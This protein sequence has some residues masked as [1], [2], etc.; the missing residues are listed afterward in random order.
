VVDTGTNTVVDTI[1]VGVNALGIAIT[2]DGS[3]AYV[4]NNLSG[5]VSVIDIATNTVVA[6][7][8]MFQPVAV[9]VSPDGT[10]AYVTNSSETFGSVSVI[11]TA[12]NTVDATIVIGPNAQ[13]VAM[14]PDGSRAYA[15]S[16]GSDSVWV[17]DTATNSVITSVP[18][19]SAPVGVAVT[20]GIGP[21][22]A[23][24]QCKRGGWRTFTLPRTFK[25]QGECV[26]SVTAGK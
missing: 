11:D 9:A 13:G 16:F 20:P 8:G 10:R 19:G 14:A 5:S 17:I 1:G 26:S 6:T 4:A 7:I 3:R 24:D 12:S 18:V 21:P 23:K 25:N 2:P 22:T 15:V